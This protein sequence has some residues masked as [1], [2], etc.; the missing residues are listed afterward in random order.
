MI[1]KRLIQPMHRAVHRPA[2][3]ATALST[4]TVP[5]PAIDHIRVN[6]VAAP[7]GLPVAAQYLGAADR[8]RARQVA[9]ERGAHFVGDPCRIEAQRQTLQ[10]RV[11][12]RA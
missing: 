11:T 7:A 10:Q 5:N 8:Q 12:N 2:H 9:A 6:L 4:R 1:V 3:R